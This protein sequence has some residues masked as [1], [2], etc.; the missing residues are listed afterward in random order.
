MDTPY[1]PPLSIYEPGTWGPDDS[2]RLLGDDQCEW[3]Q[4]LRKE[5]TVIRMKSG[6]SIER[7]WIFIHIENPNFLSCLFV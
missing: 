6:F 1:A 4:N 5:L 2:A 7:N 3:E